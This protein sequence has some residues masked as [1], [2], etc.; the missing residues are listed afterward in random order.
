MLRKEKE[1]INRFF[2]ESQ[3]YPDREESSVGHGWVEISLKE[4]NERIAIA[5]ELRKKNRLEN[6]E[7][8]C[9]HNDHCCQKYTYS[10][11]PKVCWCDDFEQIEKAVK[12]RTADK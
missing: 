9:I 3:D 6:C 8:N 12:V 2:A 10:S 4:Y 7:K 11:N 1:E 5:S